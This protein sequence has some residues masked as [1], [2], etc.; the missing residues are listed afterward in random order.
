MDRRRIYIR[1]RNV[2][3]TVAGAFLCLW[4]VILVFITVS[5]SDIHRTDGS[6]PFTS[7]SDGKVMDTDND[8]ASPVWGTAVRLVSNS[9]ETVFAIPDI[10]PIRGVIV[11]LHACTHNALKFFSKSPKCALCVGL[12]E[13]LRIA[14]ILLARG[15]AILA[16]TSQD[17]ISGCWSNR[18]KANVQ[19][20]LIEFHSI[21]NPSL[22][23]SDLI[24]SNSIA[25]GASSG[26]RFAAE[27]AVDGVVKAALVMVMSLG[28]VLRERL[29]TMGN[30]MPYIY[31]APMPRDALT[32]QA[33]ISDGDRI[34]HVVG[35]SSGS[36]IILDTTTCVSLPVTTE[37]LYKRVPHMRRDMA[38][39]IVQAL[40]K[41]QHLDSNWFLIKD[42][43]VSNW[44]NVLQQSCGESCL[45][46][47]SLAP[48][49]SPLAKALHRAWAFH[50]YCSDVVEKALDYFENASVN[51]IGG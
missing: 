9:T 47:Q 16:I 2:V 37:Y 21:L 8:G 35:V 3:I 7:Q 12:S 29:A 1:K 49:L 25:I 23:N 40:L 33:T 11:L 44:R 51:Q 28:P 19:A 39:K 6:R 41:E 26:G 32:T 14:R 46:H 18:D 24:P 43:T 4:V 30:T 48:G 17:R 5:I 50:E 10:K 34:C 38:D 31:L 45:E 36:R 42:P 13:E 15:Y 20:A 22:K 27:L